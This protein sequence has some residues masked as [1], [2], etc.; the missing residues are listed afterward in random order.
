MTD[1]CIL[2][3]FNNPLK[4]CFSNKTYLITIQTCPTAD[5]NCI[6]LI[7]KPVFNELLKVIGVQN[8][9]RFIFYSD[10]VCNK[11]LIVRN[12]THEFLTIKVLLHITDLIKSN[13]K[14]VLK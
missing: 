2:I 12:L 10:L 4:V 14:I 8:Q 7:E 11:T 5:T 3:T 1:F 13:T 6:F 9:L